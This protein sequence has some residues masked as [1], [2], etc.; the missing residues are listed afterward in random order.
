M[1]AIMLA[2]GMGRRLGK[3]TGENTKCMLRVGADAA[4]TG[5][6]GA[7]AGGNIKLILV[8]GYQAAN[9]KKSVAEHIQGIEIEYVETRT[10]RRPTTF[11]HSGWPGS[12]WPPTTPFC[13]SPTSSS[14]PA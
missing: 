4:R 11:I 3:Y 7:E 6:R 9:L 2:A 10:L 8:V 12:N 5:C 14:S 1:Q 13:W